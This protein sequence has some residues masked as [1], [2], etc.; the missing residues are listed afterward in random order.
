MKI[1]NLEIV[2]GYRSFKDFMLYLLDNNI[3]S[4]E[5]LQSVSCAKLY[6]I[7]PALLRYPERMCRRCD[8]LFA[9]YF[10]VYKLVCFPNKFVYY[11][12][13]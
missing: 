10:D 11:F 5:K 12:F 9:V 4:V 1:L 8:D 6:R 7:C 3:L 2:Y 13:M